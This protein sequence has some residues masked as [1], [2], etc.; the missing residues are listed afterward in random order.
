M[1]SSP[2]AATRS[3]LLVLLLATLSYVVRAAPFQHLRPRDYPYFPDDI[4]SC[5][6]CE[7]SW[8]S[9]R[10]CAAP[11]S[12]FRNVSSIFRASRTLH[13]LS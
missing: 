12:N 9:I 6:V 7:A 2:T 4:P 10:D 1:R 8:G 11:S 5:P 3:L 13:E